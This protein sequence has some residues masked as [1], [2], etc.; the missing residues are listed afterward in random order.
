MVAFFI[1][2]NINFFDKVKNENYD[3]SESVFI[4]MKTKIKV[5]CIIH[6]YFYIYP[7]NMLYKNEG[8]KL[9]GVNNMKNS[10]SLTKQEFTI[11]ANRIHNNKYDYSLVNY[12]NNK[13]KVKI[14]C[15]KCGR[16]FEQL[17]INHLKGFGCK[18]KNCVSE[19][20]T[21]LS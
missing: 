9:C 2:D 10:K 7:N 14:I 16:I 12:K 8:C 15:K 6:G 5:K 3:F 18:C 1:M 11:R 17:P 4:N 20:I 13:T 21:N 19:S